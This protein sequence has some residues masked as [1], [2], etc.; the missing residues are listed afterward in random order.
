M[1]SQL[2]S[3]SLTDTFLT[4]EAGSQSDFPGGCGLIYEFPSLQIS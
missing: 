1:R 3:S 2:V 4:Q